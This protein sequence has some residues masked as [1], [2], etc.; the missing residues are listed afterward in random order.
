MG[1]STLSPRRLDPTL[2]NQFPHRV[3]CLRG[4]ATYPSDATV[5]TDTGRDTKED[6]SEE[7]EEEEEEGDLDAGRGRT[8]VRPVSC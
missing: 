2:A 3:G 7:P 5:T 6:W 8:G 1:A 4:A